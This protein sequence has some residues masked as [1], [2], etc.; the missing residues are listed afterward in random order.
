[1]VRG[2]GRGTGGPH[3]RPLPRVQMLALLTSVRGSAV[4]R[5]RRP[6]P[7]LPIVGGPLFIFCRLH[8]LIWRMETV[9]GAAAV[10]PPWSSSGSEALRLER[11]S[12][13]AERQIA[14]PHGQCF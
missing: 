6:T 4:A 7:L 1:M 10:V 2:A 13:P 9:P 12:E 3:P 14:G 8:F 11:G 5:D